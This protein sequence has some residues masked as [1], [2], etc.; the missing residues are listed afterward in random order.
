MYSKKKEDLKKDFNKA[1]DLQITIDRLPG[2][3]VNKNLFWACEGS[4]W[5]IRAGDTPTSYTLNTLPFY[6][7]LN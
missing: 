6:Y 7:T 1:V 5:R 2:K 4:R 3:M